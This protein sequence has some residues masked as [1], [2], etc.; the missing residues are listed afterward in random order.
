MTFQILWQ[1]HQPPP[2]GLW[3]TCHQVPQT[4]H[5]Q[6]PQVVM[7]LIFSYSWSDFAPP[8]PL[9]QP[10]QSGGVGKKGCFWNLRGKK[11]NTSAFSLTLFGQILIL[12][13]GYVSILPLPVYFLPA[14]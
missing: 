6:V 13:P 3:D 2:S 7:S 14:L 5:V 11:L 9:L 4:V 8:A 12:L 1:L 10:I